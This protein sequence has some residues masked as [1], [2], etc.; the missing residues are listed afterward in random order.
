M[1]TLFLSPHFDDLVLSAFARLSAAG[2]GALAIYPCT[3]PRPGDG[4]E[5]GERWEREERPNL[6]ALGCRWR[7]LG[8]YDEPAATFELGT[9][10]ITALAAALAELIVSSGAQ[11][12]LA[13][14]GIGRHPDH[15]VCTLA[16]LH[17]VRQAGAGTR[18]LFFSDIP[19]CLALP[20]LR[21][22]PLQLLPFRWLKAHPVQIAAASKLQ[23]CRQYR[24]QLE[25]DGTCEEIIERASCDAVTMR[26]PLAAGSSSY[27]CYWSVW[28]ERADL[29]HLIALA[30]EPLPPKLQEIAAELLPQPSDQTPFFSPT[31]AAREQR[32]SAAL[33]AWALQYPA[34]GEPSVPAGSV[35]SRGP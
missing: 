29:D 25:D 18:L 20:L 7:F 30:A 6:L 34:A 9:P 14:L 31:Y 35:G 27:E 10:R 12:L 4:G 21:G 2:S 33:Q 23:A 15:L 24:S 17:A 32:W 26:R 19:Y 5:L 3:E 1:K 11:E 8:L 22:G 13:P 16:A 28:R